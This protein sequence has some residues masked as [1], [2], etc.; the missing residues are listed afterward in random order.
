MFLVHRREKAKPKLSLSVLRV[1]ADVS[2]GRRGC[3][4][5]R[6]LCMY[7]MT[8]ALVSCVYNYLQSKS[9]SKYCKVHLC[10]PYNE[11][12]KDDLSVTIPIFRYSL[13]QF[14]HRR[15]LAVHE[16]PV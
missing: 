7:L 11:K 5:E 16:H 8:V 9:D 14:V 13:L 10:A 15:I 2:W 3:G 12:C 4:V 1:S 6:V